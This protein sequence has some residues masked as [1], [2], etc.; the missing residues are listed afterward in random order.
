MRNS[1]DMYTV[2]ICLIY[3]FW[4]LIP[5]LILIDLCWQEGWSIYPFKGPLDLFGRA[6][7]VLTMLAIVLEYQAVVKALPEKR[8][9]GTYEGGVSF[10][11]VLSC[12]QIPKL[13]HRTLILGTLI[14]GFGDLIT[15]L[16]QTCSFC[17]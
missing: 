7:S 5:F 11:G 1:V 9:D 17:G 13:A 15:G 4:S 8:Q 14:W 12:L 2:I 16:A 3:V 6:G 10:S